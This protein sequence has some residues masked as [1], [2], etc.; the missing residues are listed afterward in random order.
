[1]VIKYKIE[2]LGPT[3]NHLNLNIHN[4]GT[5]TLLFDVCVVR[6]VALLA[7]ALLL[8]RLKRSPLRSFSLKEPLVAATSVGWISWISG[9]QCSNNIDGISL[10]E[11]RDKFKCESWVVKDNLEMLWVAEFKTDAVVQIFQMSEIRLLPNPMT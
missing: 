9:C 11:W 8:R 5:Q 1:M 2:I 6:H 7:R 3:K 10:S 4:C